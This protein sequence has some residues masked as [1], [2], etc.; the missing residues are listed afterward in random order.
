MTWTHV[1]ICGVF[2]WVFLTFAQWRALP[3]LTA[4]TA[5]VR[6]ASG[7]AV[8]C[9]AVGVPH[10]VPA[11]IAPRPPPK[12]AWIP[13]A[14]PSELVYLPPPAGAPEREDVPSYAPVDFPAPV[15]AP[16]PGTLMLLG[17][18]VVALWRVR[19]I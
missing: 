16:E 7:I 14:A 13:G 1:L 10:L 2:V 11:P 4:R 8:G 17:G 15:P 5:A 9:V 19:R 18:A 12:I 6:I 3:H